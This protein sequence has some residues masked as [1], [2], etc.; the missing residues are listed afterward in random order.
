MRH[1]YIIKDGDLTLRSL[2]ENDLELLRNWRNKDHIRTC[3]IYQE[4][5]TEEQQKKWFENYLNSSDDIMFIAEWESQPIGAAALYH[6]KEETAEF[7]RLMV[8]ESIPK[9]FGKR[10]TKSICDFGFSIL[11]LREI[12][13][14][15][16]EDNVK[17]LSIY[18]KLNFVV[19]NSKIVN[20]RKVCCMSKITENRYWQNWDKE[21][22][23]KNIDDYWM[24]SETL[25]YQ[26]LGKW[27]KTELLN[28]CELLEVGCGSGLVCSELLK[29]EVITNESYK[30]GDVSC[31]MLE[32]A[33]RRFPNMNFFELDIFNI[34]LA[35]NSQTNVINIHV[36]QHL[37]RFE[38][39]I[40]ELI[41][42]TKNKLIIA[43]WFVEDIN[44]SNTAFD[45]RCLGHKFF[46]NVYSL[47]KAIEFIKN[48]SN[49][50]IKN[51]KYHYFKF[52]N[53]I[54][55]AICIDF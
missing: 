40:K 6:V 37:P 9:G 24:E 44:K 48:N 35:D 34:K 33:R 20:N 46:N 12:Y 14:D 54:N 4:I 29:N 13:L 32:I 16:F 3:F 5:I 27:L 38:E 10:I 7:G 25:W 17:A 19:I 28:N 53:D 30:G 21:N 11:N 8:G 23:S 39:A 49:K 45:G 55:C 22:I 36:L 50:Q 41:R 2:A 51:I 31:K 1:N 15:V 42:I 26:E 47:S 18:K 52:N 43:S